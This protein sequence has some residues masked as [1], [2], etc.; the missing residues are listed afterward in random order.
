MFRNKKY[1]ISPKLGIRIK[2]LRDGWTYFW[3]FVGLAAF[4]FLFYLF[5]EFYIYHFG[6]SH[7]HHWY[8][9][10]TPP[11]R[12]I[13]IIEESFIGTCLVVIICLWILDIIMETKKLIH[14]IVIKLKRTQLNKRF[15]LI[16]SCVICG[17]FLIL[18]ANY[19]S[20][21]PQLDPELK[22]LEKLAENGDTVSLHKLLNYYNDNSEIYVE[23]VEAIDSYGNEIIDEDQ[24]EP[25]DNSVNELYLERLYYWLNKGLAIN[26]PVAKRITGMRIYYDDEATAIP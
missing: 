4:S 16:L 5:L 24:N 12:F 10:K 20:S 2:R 6:N 7:F 9:Y 25:I 26:D 15:L 11:E 14:W 1:N 8:N 19:I 3:L 21:R 23:V 17:I 13:R 22:T 18:G